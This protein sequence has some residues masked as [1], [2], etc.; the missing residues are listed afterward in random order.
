MPKDTFSNLPE[1][2]KQR[3]LEAAID[4]FAEYSFETASITRITE[5]AGIAKGSFY[6]YFDGKGDIFKHIFDISGIRKM[7]YMRHLLRDMDSLTFFELFRQLY[8]AGIKFARDN[9]KL[10]A[11]ADG[12][13]KNASPAL[14]N[15]VLG[16][17]IPK[18][19]EFIEDLLTRGIGRKEI[20]PDI[21][22]KLI[23]FIL[24]SLSIT[25]SE[26]FIRDVKAED[27]MEILVMVDKML[28]MIEN[29]IKYKGE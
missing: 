29:G 22:V 14:K 3:I 23:A 24:T 25:L 27:D 8:I 7:E 28:S 16:K 1:E 6:Q 21:D 13:V 18:S 12:F 10:H 9:P 26:Y 20:D 19:N 15:E 11:I 17:A 2:K 4:E 5:A